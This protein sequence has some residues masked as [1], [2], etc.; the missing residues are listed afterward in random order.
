MK[1]RKGAALGLLA[2][3]GVANSGHASTPISKA[4]TVIAAS[5]RA[6]GGKNWDIVQGC[7]EEGLRGDGGIT[8]TTRFSLEKYGMRVDSRQGDKGRSMGFDGKVRWQSMGGK[9]DIRADPDSI[10]EAILTNYLSINGF[11]FPDRFP[12][13][14]K[15]LRKAAAAGDTFDV[16]EIAPQGGRPIEVWF[17]RGTHLIRRVVDTKGTPPVTVEASDYRRVGGLMIAYRLNILGPDGK[18][19]E[20]GAVTSFR[21]GPIDTRIF[22]PPKAR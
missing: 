1:I 7:H 10:S 9:T 22:D 17:D 6:S 20:T 19:V 16:V 21:C 11:F 3:L 5:K 15:Y 2:L 12:A 14:V 8:Y 4:E 13:T 18:V